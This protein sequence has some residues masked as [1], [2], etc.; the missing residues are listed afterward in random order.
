MLRAAAL[1]LKPLGHISAHRG[2]RCRAEPLRPPAQT[3][4]NAQAHREVQQRV[5]NPLVLAFHST[6]RDH[7][8]WPAWQQEH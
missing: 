7:A 6:P 3:S 1:P 2:P 5:N 8:S 4:G